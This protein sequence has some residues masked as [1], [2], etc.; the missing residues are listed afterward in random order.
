MNFKRVPRVLD[1]QELMDYAFSRASREARRYSPKER[2]GLRRVKKREERRI[3]VAGSSVRR[4][5][6]RILARLP[7]L[8][9]LTPFYRELIDTIV[10]LEKLERSLRTLRWLTG[11]VERLEAEYAR[12][13]RT[14]G[15][16]DEVH[17][18]RREFYGRLASLLRKIE[19]ELLFLRSARERLKNLPTVEDTFT[20]VIAGAP[21][22]GKSSL[23][24]C[25]TGAEPRVESYPFTTRQ[26]LLG[27]LEHGHRRI[28]VVDT[29]GLLDRSF[30]EM[31][32]E[33]RQCILAL[34]HLAG[35]VLF[36][37][38]ITEACG[39]PLEEQLRI[40]RG[41]VENFS[42]EV[43]PVISKADLI[44]GRLLEKLRKEEPFSRALVCSAKTGQGVDGIIKKIISSHDE[45]IGL[46][47]N[48]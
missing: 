44:D 8:G 40:Y 36:L 26:L 25:L 42:V 24:R 11:K 20:V 14:A 22:V 2:R 19:P 18:L 28:Q 27:H 33:E 17:R 23:L 9:R 39:Y 15:S 45:Q 6:N 12:R 5:L 29:P 47:T 46:N 38:D 32:P 3:V 10:G 37:F 4:Y 43:V 41:V 13:V 16:E 30:E 35:L 7:E 1:P 21:N 31:R 48:S 34:R